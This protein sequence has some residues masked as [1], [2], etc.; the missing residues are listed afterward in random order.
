MCAVVSSGASR[1]LLTSA[2]FCR[3]S[4]LEAV[5][6]RLLE[7]VQEVPVDKADLKRYRCVVRYLLDEEGD[8]GIGAR[9]NANAGGV[10]PAP[11]AQAAPAAAP[12]APAPPAPGSI[13][14]RRLAFMEL[15]GQQFDALWAAEA[16]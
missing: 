2:N 3:P 13:A 4:Y 12:A 16:E 7:V 8:H 6:L 5:C 15:A 9:L 11:L 14:A 1:G 10:A